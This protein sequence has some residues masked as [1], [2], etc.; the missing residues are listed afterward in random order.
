M[1]VVAALGGNALL[2][3]GEPLDMPTQ[4]ANAHAAARALAELASDHE[5][6]VT[7]GNG[8]QVGLL[9]LQ[10]AASGTPTPLDVLGA[11]SDGMIGYVIAQELRNQLPERE[12]VTVLTQVVVDAADPAFARPSKPIGP[13][14]PSRTAAQAAAGTAHWSIAPDGSSW[15]RVVASPQPRAIVELQAIRQ[16]SAAG[17][18]V[19]CA[20]GGGVPVRRTAEGLLEGVEAVVD[21]D[22]TAALLASDLEADALLLLTDVDAIHLDHGQPTER[23]VRHASPA[24]LRALDLA[25]GSMGPKAEAAARFAE[26]GDHRRAAIGRLEDASALLAGETG[27]TVRLVAP[28]PTSVVARNA[29]PGTPAMITPAGGGKLSP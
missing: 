22:L 26:S 9:A 7:H 16:L 5:L 3:R 24:T 2:R 27:T 21:K 25:A 15:R 23:P 18:I 12:V 28:A 14:Y 29:A 20:G 19:V 8:P 10:A 11:E 6:I 1:K 4:R 17:V 13:T